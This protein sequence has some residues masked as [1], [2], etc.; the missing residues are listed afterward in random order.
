MIGRDI[1]VEILVEKF[2]QSVAFLRE[3]G[4]VC[5]LCGE[6]VWGTLGELM[7][8]KNI[9]AEKQENIIFEL[10]RLISGE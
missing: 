8:S 5:V 4:I 10:N 6:P 3:Q 1:T 2:P 9:A 7:D